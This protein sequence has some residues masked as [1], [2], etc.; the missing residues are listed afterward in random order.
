MKYIKYHKHT[1]ECMETKNTKGSS[2]AGKN[3][4]KRFIINK[5]KK[6]TERTSR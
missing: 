3:I 4:L 6:N 2:L 5:I 1:M